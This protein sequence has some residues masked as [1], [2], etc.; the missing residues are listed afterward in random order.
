M[1][2]GG[3][4]RNF[5]LEKSRVVGQNPQERNF[6]VFYQVKKNQKISLKRRL[7]HKM[8]ILFLIFS[9]LT[10]FQQKCET[11]LESQ[12]QI[13]I[14]IWTNTIATQWMEQTIKKISR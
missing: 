14:I 7:I 8:K 4:V 12:K 1:P 3:K 9:A 13:I 11:I 2:N 6:H 10:E 5:L